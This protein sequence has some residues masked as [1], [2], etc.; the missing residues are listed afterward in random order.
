MVGKEK[1]RSAT[2]Y[3]WLWPTHYLPAQL[4]ICQLKQTG[5]K[6]GHHIFNPISHPQ[7]NYW[8]LYWALALKSFHTYI[9]L[10]M[11]K[12]KGGGIEVQKPINVLKITQLLTGEAKIRSR[13]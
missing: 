12:K 11:I 7:N 6:A 5:P 8:D 4:T 3:Y 13:V 1:H 2:T 10:Q 9:I